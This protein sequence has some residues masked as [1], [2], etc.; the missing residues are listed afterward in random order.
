[1]LHYSLASDIA[2]FGM[3][4]VTC[5]EDPASGHCIHGESE[6][7]GAKIFIFIN[8]TYGSY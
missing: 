3:A 1:M 8:E 2:D 5:L 4:M 6:L 7:I